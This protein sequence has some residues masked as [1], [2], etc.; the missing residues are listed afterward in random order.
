MVVIAANV[1]SAVIVR[2]ARKMQAQGEFFEQ[3]QPVAGEESAQSATEFV[4]NE[5]LT[6]TPST[7]PVAHPVAGPVASAQAAPAATAKAGMPK[8]GSFVLPVGDMDAVAS[9]AGLQWVNSNPERIAAVK[10]QIAAEPKPVRI[11]R[12]R[13]PA[14]VLDD[15]PLVLVETKRDL[16]NMVLP[17]EQA[18]Q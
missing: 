17:F 7:A 18:Q 16:R 9:G 11:P 5:Q 15:G 6:Q 13:P 14:I 2:K 12:E 8:I 10:A 4:A 3:N 1:A